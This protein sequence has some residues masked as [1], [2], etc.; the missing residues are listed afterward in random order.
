LGI[1][2]QHL[3]GI[4]VRIIEAAGSRRQGISAA[5]VEERAPAS[6]AAPP[7]ALGRLV[8][9]PVFVEDGGDGKLAPGA[10]ITP[11]GQKTALRRVPRA[12]AR[13]GR[14]DARYL[15]A[16]S[17]VDACE[18]VGAVAGQDFAGAGGGGGVSDGGAVAGV[19]I[20][21]ILSRVHAAINGWHWDGATGCAQTGKPELILLAPGNRRNGARMPITARALLDGVLL[22]SQT[23]KE[24]LEAHGWS[25]QSALVKRLNVLFVELLEVM[26]A[27]IADEQRAR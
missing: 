13:L 9:P 10:P 26:I 20:V 25:A 21:R 8:E 17:Y 3:E 14:D 6:I 11:L 1:A 18:R 22:Q 2:R 7:V 16:L 15:A 27:P 19:Q 4:N 5:T 24:I 23:A 12:L